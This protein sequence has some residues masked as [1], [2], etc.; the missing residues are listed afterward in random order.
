M[1]ELPE[2]ET[3]CRG[4]FK[5]INNLKVL[6]VQLINKKL[7]Y[8]IE[9]K[10]IRKIINKKVKGVIRRGKNGIIL[11]SNNLALNFHLGMTGKFIIL[12]RE[13]VLK[14]HDHLV[15]EFNKKISLV[16]NDVRKFGYLK[17]EETPL[18]IINYKNLGVEPLIINFF[19]QEL[20]DT[21]KKKSANIKSILLD[22]SYICG[23]GNI[24]ACEIL[25]K[26]KISPYK[27]GYKLKKK[28][29]IS[30]M[31]AIKDILSLA[32]IKGGSS[33]KDFIKTD[34]EL[35]YF[36]TEFK[37]YDREGKPC[38]NCNRLIER[39]KQNGRSSFYCKGC[40]NF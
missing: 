11:F 22:Q 3:V 27:K 6:D 16:Y 33:I 34:S 17:I 30:L 40:Q 5:K 9:P 2:V 1:P 28:E 7:R 13:I 18:D 10:K 36:Q 24:Y 37:V 14:K 21:I 29:F 4:L 26:A 19:I 25:F 20:F 38:Y 39:Q 15:I 35:G 31:F 32:I 8:N 12:E 23:I